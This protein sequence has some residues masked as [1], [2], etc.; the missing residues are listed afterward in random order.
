MSDLTIAGSAI[1]TEIMGRYLSTSGVG[2]TGKIDV[3]FTPTGKPRMYF[4]Q[5]YMYNGWFSLFGMTG[6]KFEYFVNGLSIFGGPTS[7]DQQFATSNS[8]VR[9]YF[10]GHYEQNSNSVV[11]YRQPQI[12][13]FGFFGPGLSGSE[14]L[15]AKSA[16]S[17]TPVSY[18]WTDLA[19]SN[20][21]QYNSSDP[22]NTTVVRPDRS[23]NPGGCT[24]LT[25]NLVSPTGL[26]IDPTGSRSLRP[27]PPFFTT[28]SSGDD[29]YVNG[30]L[31]QIRILPGISTSTVAGVKLFNIPGSLFNSYRF[32]G[33]FERYD[34]VAVAAAVGTNGISL[35]GDGPNTSTGPSYSYTIAMPGVLANGTYLLACAYDANN[36]FH[37]SAVYTQ[38]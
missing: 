1:E 31:A 18:R 3:Y 36:N 37:Q 9:I 35:Y 32:S 4:G 15:C 30:S 24:G 10:P 20:L 2:P 23:T 12:Y 25:S 17:D 19:T 5:T 8:Q 26:Y 11:R 22:N 38:F 33:P 6:V 14:I 16:V 29:I 21:I 7:I 34:C 28:N 27:V 13:F